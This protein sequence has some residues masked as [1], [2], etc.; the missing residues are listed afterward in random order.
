MTHPNETVVR[1]FLTALNS[2]DMDGL[3]E[4]ASDDFVWRAPGRTPFSGEFAGKGRAFDHFKVI[5]GMFG[6]DGIEH[7]LEIHDVLANDE[8]TAVLWTRH[9]RRASQKLD[10]NG[11]GVFHVRDGKVAEWWVIHA[12]Q[13]AFDEFFA[14]EG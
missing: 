4:L 14:P 12:D 11:V 9:L 2:G 7:R 10:V 8:H 3:D 1:R 6:A 13:Y 5:E